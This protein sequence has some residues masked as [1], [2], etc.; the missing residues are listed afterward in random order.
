MKLVQ[1]GNKVWTNNGQF[2]L[3][4]S[5]VSRFWRG[6]RVYLKD[7][8]RRIRFF[9]TKTKGLCFLSS[10]FDLWVSGIMKAEWYLNNIRCLIRQKRRLCSSLSSLAWKQIVPEEGIIRTL[11]RNSAC[12][13]SLI[14]LPY[15]IHNI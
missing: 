5:N 14:D 13:V 4:P 8:A 3:C 2:V 7:F 15:N 1:K 6:E 10:P 11:I 9:Y 12:V